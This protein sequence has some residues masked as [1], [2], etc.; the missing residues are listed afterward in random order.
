VKVLAMLLRKRKI[1][2]ELICL[3]DGW[4]GKRRRST[5]LWN[6]WPP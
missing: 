4:R 3:L 2:R 6:G 5:M 1:T